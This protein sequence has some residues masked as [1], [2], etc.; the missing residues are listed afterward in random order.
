M[1]LCTAKLGTPSVPIDR[2][3]EYG[4]YG[5]VYG[6]PTLF[7]LPLLVCIHEGTASFHVKALL[8]DARAND[9][10][11]WLVYVPKGG[12]SVVIYDD[13]IVALRRFQNRVT[14]HASNKTVA[15]LKSLKIAQDNNQWAA[16]Q[17]LNPFS[18]LS[19][20]VFA[21]DRQYIAMPQV[22]AAVHAAALTD[23]LPYPNNGAFTTFQ[24]PSGVNMAQYTK[25]RPQETRDE[26]A[27]RVLKIAPPAPP[28][29]AEKLIE[30]YDDELGDGHLD[31]LPVDDEMDKTCYKMDPDD[32]ARWTE[33]MLRQAFYYMCSNF[34]TGHEWVPWIEYIAAVRGDAYLCRFVDGNDGPQTVWVHDV[35][36]KCTPRHIDSYLRKFTVPARR[37]ARLRAI[38]GQ[39]KQ[40]VDTFTRRTGPGSDDEADERR[41]RPRDAP[42]K[43]S[44]DQLADLLA[45]L[46]HQAESEVIRTLDRDAGSM[47]DADD[48]EKRVEQA[49]QS[50]VTSL[51][52]RHLTGQ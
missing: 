19:H 2:W 26:W 30:T 49:Y 5:R 40:V 43:S 37:A 11:D 22:M 6:P 15:M 20:V 29:P 18:N 28:A 31:V 44:Q 33:S 48:I 50:K 14:R 13:K 39:Y 25:A 24:P 7:Q 32:R 36:I 42:A 12:S 51:L 10:L 38:A 41:P 16:L 35:Y 52:S 47:W 27:A 34:A 17:H 23:M 21:D 8:V 4:P 46:R 3:Q 1:A 45:D 9:V